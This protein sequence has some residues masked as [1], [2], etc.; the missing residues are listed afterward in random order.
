MEK[1]REELTIT[2]ANPKDIIDKTDRCCNAIAIYLK[3]LQRENN[4]YITEL[5]GK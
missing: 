4:Y 2:T 5:K 3:T 1:S